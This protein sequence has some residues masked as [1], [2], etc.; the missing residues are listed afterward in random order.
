MVSSA[1]WSLGLSDFVEALTSRENEISLVSSWHVHS[2]LSVSLGLVSV[3]S[4]EAV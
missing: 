3:D 2:S 1:N 4:S